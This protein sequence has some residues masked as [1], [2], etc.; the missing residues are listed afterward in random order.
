MDLW[1]RQQPSWRYRGHIFNP[2]SAQPNT[3]HLPLQAVKTVTAS[4]LLDKMRLISPQSS[5]WDPQWHTHTPSPSEAGWDRA[6]HF[7][8]Q[9]C[10]KCQHCFRGCRQ[11]L[12]FLRAT[13]PS[14]AAPAHPLCSVRASQQSR[15]LSPLIPQPLL[16][17]LLS[18]CFYGDTLWNKP[19]L[20][21]NKRC[22]Q[23]K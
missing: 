16:T 5:Q 9:F 6:W 12:E 21:A 15:I 3:S 11:A 4:L 1:Q 10:C 8:T 7:L 17:F 14:G 20:W 23:F 2:H 22:G 19:A 18:L 13:R